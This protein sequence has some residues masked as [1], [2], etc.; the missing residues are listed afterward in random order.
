[1]YLYDFTMKVACKTDMVPSQIF[2]VLTGI[3]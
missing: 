3:F 2:N 1:M